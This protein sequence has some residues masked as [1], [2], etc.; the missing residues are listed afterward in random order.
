MPFKGK[1]PNAVFRFV[2]HPGTKA[3]PFLTPA[4]EVGKEVLKKGLVRAVG[5]GIKVK[6]LETRLDALV[7]TAAFAVQ[8]AA[9]R[10]APV[11]TGRLKG[12]INVAKRGPL[13][14]T[15]GS[16]VKYA[17]WV[18]EG[19][20]PHII[21]P[22]EKKALAFFWPKLVRARGKAKRSGTKGR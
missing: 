13:F 17:R 1:K 4:L 9:Q 8:R 22:R 11:D 7:R 6:S 10:L 3:Q 2:R 19:T 5:L 12:S 18:D 20:K 15:I 16:N 21:R 14:Y